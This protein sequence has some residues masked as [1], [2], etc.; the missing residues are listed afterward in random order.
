MTET[1]LEEAGRIVNGERRE[2]YGDVRTSFMR[3]ADLWS[4]YL[5][6]Q[7]TVS[8]VAHMMILMKVSRNAKNFKRDN[9]TDICGY[10]RCAE[11]L[12]EGLAK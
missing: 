1:I 9:L 12:L 11:M 4:A 7:V 3:I 10:A 2:A 5:G 6:H 8:D